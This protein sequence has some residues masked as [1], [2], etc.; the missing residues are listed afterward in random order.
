MRKVLLLTGGEWHDYEGCARILAD[1]LAAQGSVACDVSS[2]R[3]ALLRLSEY[4]SVVLY[5]QGGRLS[6]EQEKDLCDWVR[7]GGS[8]IGIHSAADSWCDNQAYMEMLGSQF[9]GHGPVCEFSVNISDAH[10]PVMRGFRDFRVTDEFYIL[11]KRTEANLHWLASGNWQT[12]LHP[13]AYV[14]EYGRGR[15]FYT[16][17]GHDQRTF[18][19][20]MFQKLILRALRWTTRADQPGPVRMGVIGYGGSFS[21]GKCHADTIRATAGLALTAIC[22]V[23]PQRLAVAGQEHPGTELFPSVKAM[24]QSGTVDAAVIVTPHDTHAAIGMQLLEAGIGV[25]CEKPFCL[26][27]DEATRLINLARER[28]TLLTVFHN[29]RWDADYLTIQSI[30][31][32]GLIGEVFQIE[33][34]MAEYKHPGYWWRSHKPVSGGVMYDWGAHFVDWILNL[35]PYRMESVSGFLHKRIWHDVTNEDHGKLLIR[36]EGGR[37]AELEISYLAAVDKPKWRILGTWGGLTSTWDPPVRVT[38]FLGGKEEKLE[39]PFIDTRWAADFYVGLVDHLLGGD[40]LQVTPESG[41]RI[42]AVLE[43]A[44]RSSETGIAQ[45]VPIEASACV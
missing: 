36:F 20:P 13:L 31:A 23:E 17:L 18:Q 43:L 15:V 8:L 7:A 19:H 9:I 29:R 35:M 1:Y 3:Q 12:A 45:T 37:T 25:I 24:I 14:R 16:A 32:R 27:I 40:P 42:I 34:C 30:I 38:S 5:T 26:T 33:A 22:E 41:R 6:D 21:M 4:S 44:G 2:D 28:Q 11:R 39:V 10:H